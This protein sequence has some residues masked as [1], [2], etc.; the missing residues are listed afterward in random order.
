M[1]PLDPN[2]NKESI[3]NENLDSIPNQDPTTT[4]NQNP[5]STQKEDL[6][7]VQ[8]QLSDPETDDR[9]IKRSSNKMWK[10]IISILSVLAV[11]GAAFV[12]FTYFTEQENP[13]EEVSQPA[14]QLP[15]VSESPAEEEPAVAP[16]PEP[17]SEPEPDQAPTEPADAT[18]Y[19]ESVIEPTE[20]TVIN[21]I[22]L[23]NKQNPL[24]ASYEPGENA[25]ARAAYNAMAKEAQKAGIELIA[26]STF[27]GY[28]RQKELYE[29]Y[30]AKDGQENADRYSARPGFS[31]H[32]TGL[33]FD[34]GEAGREEHWASASFGETEAGK[35]VAANAHKYGFILRYPEGME[36]ITGYMHEAW[37]FRYVG[38][39]AAAEIYEQGITLEQ[40]LGVYPQ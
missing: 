23:A 40:Y 35:W 34:I 28:A 27:R 21:G 31:E 38:K 11:C 7:F 10:A 12:Y 16:S 30:V 8:S 32:Q 18:K 3:Q 25:E 15:A 33:A 17:E 9:P 4:E 13:V 5:D 2:Q 14:D 39:E 20:P 26:F 36:Q 24:P 29:G 22:L 37:H 6:N 1:E 19:P